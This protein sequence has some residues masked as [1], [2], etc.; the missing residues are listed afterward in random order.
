MSEK[1]N[2]IEIQ[3][4]YYATTAAQYDEMHINEEEIAHTIAL[5]FLIGL[6]DYLDVKSI[7]DVGSGTGRAICYIQKYRPDINIV[8][9][10]PVEE[11]RRIGYSKG[12]SQKNLI[13]GDATKLQFETAEFDLVCEFGVLHH[14]RKPELAV[15]EMIRVAKKGIFISDINNFGEG[16]LLSRSIKQMLNFIRLW[17]IVNLIKTKGKGY[18]ISKGDGLSYSY[19]VFNNYKQ[20][21][22]QCNSV[23]ILNTQTP[24]RGINPYRNAGN[25]AILG[26]KNQTIY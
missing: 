24:S 10:E 9:I 25:I 18:R 12:I 6:I 20:I 16:S 5:S 19:S 14:L 11:L 23:H 13:Y 1:T 4:H 2:E 3:K 26:I 17:K 21:K 22:N 15:S 7:L 8:G